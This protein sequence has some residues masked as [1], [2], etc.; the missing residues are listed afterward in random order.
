MNEYV[1]AENI[2]R[3]I[4]RAAADLPEYWTLR[5]EVERGVTAWV[6][7]VDPDGYHLEAAEGELLSDQI[8][9]VIDDVIAEAGR[10]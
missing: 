3:A 6:Y 9:T 8:N 5:I 2:G 7:A 1:E 4:Q 10:E